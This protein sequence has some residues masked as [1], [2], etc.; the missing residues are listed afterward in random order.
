MFV[1]DTSGSIGQNNFQRIRYFVANI[2]IELFRTSI[3]PA[4]GVILF[5]S[6]AR[7]RFNLQAHTDLNSLLSAIQNIPY[8]GGST[9]TD[10][11][12]RLLLSTARDGSLGLRI[13]SLKI[14]IVITD[15][16]STDPDKTTS[17]ANELHASRI[18][19]VYAAGIGGADRDELERIAN[20]NES[21]F[22]LF[23][24]SFENAD[25][26]QLQ[27]DILPGLCIRKLDKI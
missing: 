15:G 16:E 11:A 18:F 14:A 8:N 4:V 5:S 7:I 3:S 1:I 10:D 20:A 23:A 6:N 24:D 17:A 27:E 22:V 13:N 12:L 19:D 9:Y 21:E 2:T 26:Q 25:L